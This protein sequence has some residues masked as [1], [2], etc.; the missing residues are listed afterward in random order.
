MKSKN[1][2]DPY[3]L[4]DVIE[5]NCNPIRRK[6]R[7]AQKLI[8]QPLTNNLQNENIFIHFEVDGHRARQ[9][10]SSVGHCCL[11]EIST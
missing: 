5:P 10:N 7:K 2:Y 4:Y 6:V 9:L 11:P 3:Q 8:I 1:D